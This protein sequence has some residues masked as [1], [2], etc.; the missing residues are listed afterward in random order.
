[1]RLGN[2]ILLLAFAIPGFGQ[3][4]GDIDVRVTDQS[5]A[6]VPNANVTIRSKA[7]GTTRAAASDTQGGVRFTQLAIGDYEVRVE[8]P[9][10]AVYSAPA[11]VNSG[12]A[13]TV[14]IT[15]EVK[16]TTEQ[17]V[18]VE[19]SVQLNTVNSQL[20]SSTDSQ[21]VTSLPIVNSGVLA[22]AGTAPGVI[23][24]TPRNPFLG[25]GSF[26]SNGGRG[27]GNNIT[28]D[29][30]TARDVSTTGGAGLGTLPIDAIKEVNLVTNSFSAEFGRNASAQVQ[31]LSK[32]GSNEFHG[33]A[34]EFLRNDVF[35]ARDYF[36]RTGKA[37][38]LR[39]NDWGVTGGGRII[40]DKLF[41]FG[42]YEQQ[43]IRGAGG[44]RIASV[45]TPAQ[46]SAITDPTSKQLLSTL[47][48]PTDPSGTV[49]NAASNLADAWALSGRVDANLTSRDFFYVRYGISNSSSSSP[50][51]TFISSNLPTNGATSTN[52]PQ[53]GTVSETHTFGATT[54]NNF[55]VSFGRSRP[56]FQ[57]LE[58]FGGPEVALGDGSISN[59]GIWSGI[60]QGRVQNT[61]QFVDTL[62]H[63]R[64][65]HQLKFGADI[66]RIQ[67]NSYFDSNV[68]GTLTFLNL[69]DFQ[70]GKP[71]Q[72][73]QRFGGSVRGNRVTNSYFFAQDDYRV[74]RFLTLNLGVRLEV[75]NGVSEVNNILSNLDL[76]STAAL[77]GAGSG[78]LGAFV[79]G[80]TYFNTTKNWA[81]RFGFAWNPRGGKTS[82]RGG[83]GISYDFIYLNPITNGRFLPPFMYQ[84]SLPQTDFVGANSYGAIFAG[85]SAFQTQGRATVGTFGTTIKNFGAV[86]PID[87]GL[88]NPQVQQFSLTVERELP[89][90]LIGRVSYSGTKG[91]F[92]Q[93]SRPLNTLSP[94]LFTPPKTV[95][96]ETAQRASGLYTRLNA[97][98][99]AAFTSSSNRIDPRFNGVTLV[100]SSANS[101][102]HSAQFSVQRRFVRGYTFTAAY[103]ISKSIDDISDALGVLANDSASQQNPFDNRNN[104]AVSQF[105]IPQ[106]L[107]ITHEFEPQVFAGVSNPVLRRVLH[108][109]Q[110]GGIF[111]AQSG[112]PVNLFSGTRAGLADPTLLGG[113]GVVRPNVTGPVRIDFKANPGLGGG[114]PN[115]VTGSGLAQPLVGA[116]GTLGRNR[117]RQNAQIQSDMTFGKEFAITEKIKTRF[118]AQVENVFNNTTFSRP[119]ATFSAPTTFG[120][121]ADTDSNSRNMTMTMRVIW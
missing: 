12:A 28:I 52:R 29:S 34:F 89:F 75:N 4:T 115:L 22:L 116:F 87:R 37:S 97:G 27:R 14:P 13:T 69:A 99:N 66:N 72:Y 111:Q 121:Y 10:F 61:Y 78:P 102:Y 65:K 50:G 15:L 56:G 9:G 86:S 49:S 105:D 63:T 68:R 71:F 18:V 118:Q 107:V 33:S 25:L 31:I 79:A 20:Q 85:T 82:I 76:N 91:N 100:E 53:N 92:L 106:R 62:T 6:A 47:K 26:N 83:Y 96:E 59:M 35:N 88:K 80:G 73:S 21:A 57:P 2:F 23:P 77:G 93:R 8:S 17:V 119:G 32:S 40:K 46:A 64:G 113:N 109:W 103:T 16:G 11:T 45:P 94:G 39:N 24:V 42:T 54:V 1:M 112:F 7:T 3:I 67:A 74:S 43:K 101:N 117:L 110:F 120:Y 5:G 90:Q 98:L 30:A 84:F 19:T 44:T 95:E 58:T 48:V 51:L 55:L 41:F 104:R 108:G 70:A 60:P 38:I 81:P 36:D 114:N